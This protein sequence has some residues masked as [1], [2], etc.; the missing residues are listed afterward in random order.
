MQ[1]KATKIAPPR[2][3][4]TPGQTFAPEPDGRARE[5]IDGLTEAEQAWLD[6][7][8]ISRK[9]VREVMRQRHGVCG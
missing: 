1:D 4:R 9:Q 5:A 7:P 6:G 8:G 2:P 3:L